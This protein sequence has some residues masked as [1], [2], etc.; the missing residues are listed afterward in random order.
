[1]RLCIEAANRAK[2]PLLKQKLMNGRTLSWEKVGWPSPPPRIQHSVL[3]NTLGNEWSNVD[4]TSN[5]F[6]IQATDNR[7]LDPGT[8]MP[9]YRPTIQYPCCSRERLWVVEDFKGRYRN[10]RNE[11]MNCIFP[12]P[13]FSQIYK[14]LHL[15]SVFLVFWLTL[16]WPWCICASCLTR[17]GCPCFD[18]FISSRGL[19]TVMSTLYLKHP[20]GTD[21]KAKRRTRHLQNKLIS[22]G[23]RVVLLLLYLLVVTCYIVSCRK[24][25]L[26]KKLRKKLRL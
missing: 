10:D 4:Y 1:M 18:P 23:L 5:G 24:L 17:T 22:W 26:Q 20:P 6:C 11:W 14:F 2:Q 8:S 9:P 15:F 25:Q 16:L 19:A 12:H 13:Y 3:D 21:F 7:H